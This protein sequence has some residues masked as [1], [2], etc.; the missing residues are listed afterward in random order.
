[1]FVNQPTIG[2]ERTVFR[3]KL[4][5]FA[6]GNNVRHCGEE[7]V[8]VGRAAWNI[9][10]R[11]AWEHLLQA[12]RPGGVNPG[13]GHTA[14]CRTGTNRDNR[15]GIF[16]RFTDV[17]DNRFARHHAI[18]AVVFKRNRT[19]YHQNVLPF[20]GFQS[21]VFV[22]FDLVTKRGAQ[23]FVVLQRD[24]FQH[25]VFNGGMCCAKQRF[26]TPSTLLRANPDHGRALALCNGLR[27][28][29]SSSAAKP[30]RGCQCGTKLH[31]IATINA[32]GGKR[33]QLRNFVGHALSFLCQKLALFLHWIQ[34][35]GVRV[36]SSNHTKSVS[37]RTKHSISAWYVTKYR[38][39]TQGIKTKKATQ[40]S[41]FLKG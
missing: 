16:C 13:C 20:I 8:W 27:H 18:N 32:A 23:Y 36:R 37:I 17:V 7:I 34:A 1:M 24:G 5:R 21:V 11:F 31:K 26:S 10:H 28:L 6:K 41:G 4:R 14:P 38:G 3:I 12:H 30:H 40:K 2:K 19:V 39:F 35:M 22:L 25:K 15:R 29:R 9:N 33:S